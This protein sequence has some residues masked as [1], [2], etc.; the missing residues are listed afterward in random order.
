MNKIIKREHIDI[1]VYKSSSA[2]VIQKREKLQ[3]YDHI[4]RAG[5]F[6][7]LWMN[8]D[9][10]KANCTYIMEHYPKIRHLDI[11]IRDFRNM[12]NQKSMVLLYLFIEK[13]KLSEIQE[14]SRFAAGLEKLIE[15]VE[16]SVTNP[17]SN[18]FVEGTSNKLKMIKRT[19]YGRCSYQLLE[20]K[21]MYRPSV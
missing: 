18:G 16:N 2:E 4:S 17:L 13:Y 11:C 8:S 12:Y 10:S 21:L 15:A 7:L 19:R 5:I 14:L 9:L 3:Q 6:R 1:A 20:A